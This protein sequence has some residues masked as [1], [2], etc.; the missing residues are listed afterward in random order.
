MKKELGKWFMDVAKYLLTAGI[1]APW[2]TNPGQWSEWVVPT[3]FGAFA[4]SV[5]IGLMI[6][7]SDENRELKREKNRN[8]SKTKK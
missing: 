8:R 3:V 6:L 7:K 4:I 2:I 5:T 1:V